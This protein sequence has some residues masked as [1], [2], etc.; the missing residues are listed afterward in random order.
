MKMFDLN[1]KKAVVTGAARGLGYAMAEALH[2]AGAEVVC[3]DMSES[4]EHASQ[5]LTADGG[6]LAYAIKVN[7]ADREAAKIA[8][9]KACSILGGRIDILV[10]A[11]GIQRRH[12]CEV[13]P[14]DDWNDVIQVNLTALFFLCQD[15]GKIM[16][17]QKKGK[18]INIAS[19]LSFFGGNEIPAYAA[20]KGGVAQVSKTLSNEWMGKG[21]NVNCIAPGYMKTDISRDF[22][23]REDYK[24]LYENI[25]SRIPAGRWGEPNDMKGVV[26]FLASAASDYISGTV[27]PV[28][29]GYMV[30]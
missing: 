12:P 27:I 5:K 24:P 20:S 1:G 13:F 6:S 18:I 17:Q 19:M 7:V 3:M 30:R 26:T 21:I 8:V 16:L 25:T 9:E 2:E 4:V 15:V 11:A 22:F 23:E 28:D 29:G 14:E 10:N